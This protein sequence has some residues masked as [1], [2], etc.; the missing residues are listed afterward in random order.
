MDSEFV[1]V[2]SMGCEDLVQSVSPETAADG[3]M[4]IGMGK[5][6]DPET[7]GVDSAKSSAGRRLSPRT[8]WWLGLQL[9]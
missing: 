4:V 6:V 5:P 8:V 9:Y 1:N 7:V 3:P 2:S